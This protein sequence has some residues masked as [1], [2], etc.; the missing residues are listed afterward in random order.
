MGQENMTFHD[1]R[2]RRTVTTQATRRKQILLG[3]SDQV[4]LNSNRSIEGC[5]P[6]QAGK[7]NLLRSVSRD[8][9]PDLVKDCVGIKRAKPWFKVLPFRPHGLAIDLAGLSTS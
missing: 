6:L 5:K 9:A 3:R 4:F 2:E 8:Y 7:V 1:I